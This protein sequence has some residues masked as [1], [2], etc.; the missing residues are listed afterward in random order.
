M[1]DIN[2]EPQFDYEVAQIPENRARNR[3]GNIFPCTYRT[4]GEK[5]SHECWLCTVYAWLILS[6]RSLDLCKHAHAEI[7]IHNSKCHYVLDD[8]NRVVLKS[9]PDEGNSDYINASYLDV[10]L[11]C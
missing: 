2:R 4:K 6:N 7:Y 9:V 10:S 11:H 1:Q 8:F 5:Q 3:F